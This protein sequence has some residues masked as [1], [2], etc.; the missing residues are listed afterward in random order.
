MTDKTRIF[1]DSN[2]PMYAAGRKHPNKASSIKILKSIS[3]GKLIGITS[4]EVFK[5][6]LYR[7][8]AIDLLK[9]GFEVFDS[10]SGIIDQTLSINSSIINKARNILENK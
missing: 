6:I 3:D 10:F 8:Q 9:K 2:I 7:Y 4:T 5:E 1:V